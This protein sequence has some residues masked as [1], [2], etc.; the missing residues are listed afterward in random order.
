MLG[1]FLLSLVGAMSIATLSVDS[2]HDD[3]DTAD[4]PQE[5]ETSTTASGSDMLGPLSVET[6][7]VATDN[8]A[9]SPEPTP[10]YQANEAATEIAEPTEPTGDPIPAQTATAPATDGETITLTITPEMIDHLEMQHTDNPCAYT[11]HVDLTQPTDQFECDLPQDVSGQFFLIEYTQ[12]E[13]TGDDDSVEMSRHLE[14]IYTR[15]GTQP[16]QE[17]LMGLTP[18]DMHILVH[19]DLGHVLM[20]T[21]TR[22]FIDGHI[23]ESPAL[24]AELQSLN[25]INVYV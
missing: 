12:E 21:E 18:C 4:T 5:D 17:Q 6:D 20:D 24:G 7:P 2:G 11:T 3:S 16:T 13:P 10:E 22:D 15:D 23:N 19:I 8:T 14:L 1:F 9:P 25:R